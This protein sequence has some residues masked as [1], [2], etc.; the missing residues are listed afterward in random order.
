MWFF[1][2]ALSG[3]S[4]FS[5]QLGTGSREDRTTQRGRFCSYSYGHG[6]RATHQRA[7][8]AAALWIVEGYRTSD[9]EA[10]LEEFAEDVDGW[11]PIL[12]E[13]SLPELTG[14]MLA[15][16]VRRKVVEGNE[17]SSCGSEGCLMRMLL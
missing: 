12:K 1:R 17:G 16:V 4:Q 7:V 10:S 6:C 14:E 9:R 11:L 5:L 13:I 2:G 15:D 3:S 8:L